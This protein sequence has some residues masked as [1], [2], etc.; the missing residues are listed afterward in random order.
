MTSPIAGKRIVITRPRSQAA[1]LV[2]ALEDLGARAILFPTIEIVPV[3]DKAQIDQAIDRLDSFDWIIFTSVNGVS[4]FWDRMQ[5]RN[6]DAAGLGA[7]RVAAIGPATAAELHRRGASPD[8]VPDEYV[9]DRIPDGL[10]D[11]SGLNV[12]LPRAAR[13]RQDLAFDLKNRGAVITDLAV[14]D[15][16]S[17]TPDHAAV[18]E[19]K[20]GVDAVTFTS[21]STVQHFVEMTSE[22]PDILGHSLVACIGPITAA[23]ARELQIRVDIVAPEYTTEGVVK[24]LVQLFTQHRQTANH[25]G[26]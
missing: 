1:P 10:G 7:P 13:A 20:H 3:S 6:P 8:F 22:M 23:T 26:Q 21:S 19:L 16:I 11:V 12:L 9:A 14:Y 18:A 5:S 2:A 17:P 15:T 4:L 24:A 25:G